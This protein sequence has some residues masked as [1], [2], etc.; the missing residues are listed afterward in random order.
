MGQNAF[1][2]VELDSYFQVKQKSDVNMHSFM[3]LHILS[4]PD[5]ND[6]RLLLAGIC[7][8]A[9]YIFFIGTVNSS[10]VGINPWNETVNLELMY[11][12]QVIWLGSA[13]SSRRM[14]IRSSGR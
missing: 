3:H 8:C 2:T 13:V 1:I 14:G 6:G 12:V 10:Y 11:V 4:S 7:S 9:T 5:Y